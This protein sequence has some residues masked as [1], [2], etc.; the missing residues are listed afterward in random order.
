MDAPPSGTV[1]FLF[2]DMVDSTPRWEQ[3]RA[4]MG[5]LVRQHDRLLREAI[6]AHG[7]YVF[8]GGGDGFCAAFATAS[9]ALAAALAAQRALRAA[10]WG[11][12]GPPHVRVALHT[13]ATE[14]RD[15]DYFGLA[16][17]QVNRLIAA[18]H[19]DQILLTLV[20]RELVRD[21]LPPGISLRDLGAHHFR[22]ISRPQRVFQVIAPDLPADFP[23]IRTVDPR[24]TNLPTSPTPLVG[25]EREVAAAIALL[26]RPGARLLTL[27]GP[28]GVGKTRLGLRVAAELL[29]DFPGGAW[30]VSLADLRDPALLPQAVA[31]ALAVREVR[32][33]PLMT[34]LCEALRA[35]SPLLLL[36]D[37]F[38]HLLT[39][40]PLLGDLLV[41]A[42]QLKVLTTSRAPLRLGGEQEYPVP[43]LA[44]PTLRP[45]PPAEQV[46]RYEAV[47]LFA[48]RAQAVLVDFAITPV[49][50]G[51]VAEICHRLD[52]LPLA[53]ELAAAQ[54]RHL[55]PQ[56]ILERLERRL[57]LLAGGARDQV[58]RQRTL[59]RTIDWSYDLLEPTEQALF[60]R[61]AVFVGGCTLVAAEAVCNADGD[62]GT[63][64]L[65]GLAALVAT[66]LLRQTEGN[67]GE[68]RF[69]MLDTIREYALERLAAGTELTPLRQGHAQYYLGLAEAARAQLRGPEQAAWLTRLA[70]EHE[71]LLAALRW[72]VIGGDNDLE[73]GLRLAESLWPAWTMRSQLGEGRRWLEA[74][75]ARQNSLSPSARVRALSL[76]GALARAQGDYLRAR[77]LAEEVL[78][79]CRQRGDVQG[80]AAGLATLAHLARLEGDLDRAEVLLG[81]SLARWRELGD[82]AATIGGLNALGQLAQRRGDHAEATARYD[83]ALALARAAGDERYIAT[84]VNNLGALA[85]AQGDAVRARALLEESLTLARRRGDR[86]GIAARLINLGTAALEQGDTARARAL[87]DESLAPARAIGDRPL[88][89]RSLDTL[90][91]LAWEEGDHARAKALAEQRLALAR[92]AG[93]QPGITRALTRLEQLAGA[94][95]DHGPASE[96]IAGNTGPAEP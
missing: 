57:D 38:E 64:V 47:Q 25:R 40:A 23:P 6:A 77:A 67:T 17:S 86:R 29:D 48:A 94:P 16:L 11:D 56:A 53:L 37:N 69:G 55:S 61:L 96:H 4:A 79:L 70:D 71:N 50:A 54:I 9:R 20:T 81:E 87:L 15:G 59:R 51:L 83:E 58:A 21:E 43:T 91:E 74:V 1:T 49:N 93:D 52:G 3:D 76:G 31:G 22:G 66:S 65:G 28:G 75:L 46:A 89:G 18:M 41:A 73:R 80:V 82:A 35:R 8:K 44:V 7:G 36:L 27:T 34:S 45:L 60:R 5:A 19:G 92:E 68:S 14:E 2:T 32:G 90:W 62:L 88:L 42:P 12:D 63:G 84:L 30:L 39:A 33:E 95:G 26:R 78:T 10:Q 72:S 85:H 24:P 13:G